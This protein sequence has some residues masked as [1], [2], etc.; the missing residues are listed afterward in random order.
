MSVAAI[1]GMSVA[2]LV[3]V[4]AGC[5]QW[6]R[7]RHCRGNHARG[8]DVR[9]NSVWAVQRRTAREIADAGTAHRRL[10]A[11]VNGRLRH[12]ET[13]RRPLVGGAAGELLCGP[14]IHAPGARP[15]G[16]APSTK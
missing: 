1:V 16:P 14:Y 7:C 5:F 3:V 12:R 13:F 4:V 8:F 11:R 10:M 15:Q 2:G 9:L 6:F